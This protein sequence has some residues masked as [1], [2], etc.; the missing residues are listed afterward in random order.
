MLKL[1]SKVAL[2]A[3]AARGLGRCEALRLAR[4][5][6]DDVI[7]DISLEA[8]KEF[9]EELTA[10]TVIDE[11]KNLGRCSIGIECDVSI[12]KK[13]D[14]MFEKILKEFGYID[15]VVNNAGGLLDHPERSFASTIPEDDF[16]RTIDRNLMS[17]ISCCQAASIPMKEQ[18][19]GRIV[20]TSSVGG[21]RASPTE[22]YSSY[23]TTK[24]GVIAYTRSLAG[25]LAPFGIN[26]NCIAPASIGS[27][28][29]IRVTSRLRGRGA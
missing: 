23:G 6:A 11:I 4:L 10:P 19:S 24:A 16:R 9:N 12:K 20:N 27:S 26:V 3:G 14:A 29:Y 2:I 17:C 21:L 13:V 15:I 18:R 7:N 1:E 28:R 5:R 25:E 22:F 8:A